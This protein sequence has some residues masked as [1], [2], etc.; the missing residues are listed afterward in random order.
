M[1]LWWK[2]RCHYC[3]W[4]P[5]AVTDNEISC[6]RRVKPRRRVYST[7]IVRLYQ[8]SYCWLSDRKMVS[9]DDTYDNIHFTKHIKSCQRWCHLCWNT[10]YKACQLYQVRWHFSQHRPDNGYYE[11]VTKGETFLNYLVNSKQK[12]NTEC[13]NKIDV[14]KHTKAVSWKFI[15]L[16]IF[17]SPGISENYD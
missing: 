12:G 1:Q 9:V 7:D 13:D 4:P 5:S 10:C 8:F 15:T 6:V 2:H 3:Q 17:R 16:R 11:S 14:A